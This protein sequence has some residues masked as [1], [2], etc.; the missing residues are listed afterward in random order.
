MIYTGFS[1]RENRSLPNDTMPK[2]LKFYVAL[3]CLVCVAIICV[4]PDLDLPDTVLRAKQLAL[5]LLLA[6]TALAALDTGRLVDLAFR[7]NLRL[8]P[9]ETSNFERFLPQPNRLCV[10]LC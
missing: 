5:L 4:A 10:F 3:A 2:W 6:I 9:S 1:R 7:S 8:S